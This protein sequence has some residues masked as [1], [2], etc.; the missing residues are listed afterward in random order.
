MGAEVSV[1]LEFRINDRTGQSVS[2][3][4]DEVF[5]ILLKILG[6]ARV[7]LKRIYN[8]KFFD[9]LSGHRVNGFWAKAEL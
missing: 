9:D 5:E 8:F 6:I 7:F 3:L 4:K 1:E 2:W